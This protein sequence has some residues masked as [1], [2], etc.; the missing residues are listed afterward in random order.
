LSHSKERTEK[1]CL[2]CKA[3]LVGRFCHICGQENIEPH[4]SVWGLIS[5]FFEDITHFDGKF[6]ST[7]RYLITRPG[8]LSKEFI[9][10]R[11]ASYLHPIR[12]Y[13]FTSAVFFLVFYSLFNPRNVSLTFNDGHSKSLVKAANTAELREKALA[14][15]ENAEDSANIINAFK[16]AD[17]I[18]FMPKG[19][20]AADSNGET[21]LLKTEYS[22]VAQYDSAQNK[23][24]ENERDGWLKRRI[25]TKSIQIKAKYKGNT[26][27]F[28]E[29]VFDKFLHTFPTLLFVSLPL[30][31]LF[32]KL[33][34]IR[35]R[36]YY[37]DHGI[38]L[39]H[40]YIF[41]FLILLML[42][43]LYE[44]K[45]ATNWG[46]LIVL[47]QVALLVYGVIYTFRA[48]KN[49]YQQGS[50]KTFVKFSLLNLLAFVSIM[51]LFG[52]FFTIAVLRV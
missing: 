39:I 47:L 2:N 32:L 3:E 41:T 34:Y 12:M 29:D 16:K 24:P 18:P 43:G 46:T 23:L 40:L 42:F 25:E 21:A 49:F 33:L 14:E 48:M 5:H 4:G 51:L 7:G 45:E 44:L 30:Y 36:F 52:L 1:I 10:G 22:S 8:F 27:A 38:F 13:V 31:A 20:S 37:V 9:N 15:A 6:F 28:F 26:R 50:F 17:K 35:R 19:D 11:R